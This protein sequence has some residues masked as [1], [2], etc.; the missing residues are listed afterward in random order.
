MSS[1]WRRFTNGPEE[2]TGDS[3]HRH[4]KKLDVSITT[5]VL[6]PR[7]WPVFFPVDLLDEPRVVV[8]T[9]VFELEFT[10]QSACWHQVKSTSLPIKSGSRCRGHQSNLTAPSG[11]AII[12]SR[13]LNYYLPV[14]VRDQVS[15]ESAPPNPVPRRRNCYLAASSR[16]YCSLSTFGTK[17]RKRGGNVFCIALEVDELSLRSFVMVEADADASADHFV[18]KWRSEPSRFSR[19]LESDLF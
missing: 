6:L 1:P 3:K 2:E 9:V 14:A 17:R 16:E 10:F 15:T 8:A 4:H 19:K 7:Q 18:C 13:S 12:S 5:A 11:F